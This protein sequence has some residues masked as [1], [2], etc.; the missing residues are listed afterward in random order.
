MCVIYTYHK[1]TINEL[2]MIWNKNIADNLGDTRWL[3][4]KNEAIANNKANKS[5]TFVVLCDNV[6]IG[7]GSL[8]FS[9]DCNAIAGRLELSNNSSIANVNALRIQKSHEEQ[10]HISK[11]MREIENYAVQCGY[12]YL[13]IGVEASETRN[14]AIYLHW[15]Y[16]KFVKSEIEDDVLVLYYRKTL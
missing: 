4:W 13:T 16:T 3:V 11:L 5:A 9:P 12:S 14:L 8:L 10:G 6:P 1:A 2:E 15:G 7:E